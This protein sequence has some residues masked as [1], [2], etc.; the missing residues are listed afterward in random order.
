MGTSNRCMF[1]KNKPRLLR[2]VSVSCM[3]TGNAFFSETLRFPKGERQGFRCQYFPPRN[4]FSDFFSI[5]CRHQ[6]SRYI[7]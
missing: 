3:Y 4:D 6:L 5:P 2:L 7:M 1:T